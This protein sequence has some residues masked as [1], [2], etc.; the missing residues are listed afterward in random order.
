MPKNGSK[1]LSPLDAMIMDCVWQAGEASVREV[2]ERLQARK[3]MAY[4]TVLTMM[5]LCRHSGLRPNTPTA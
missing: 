2:Q 4:N 5:R 1:P 3:P